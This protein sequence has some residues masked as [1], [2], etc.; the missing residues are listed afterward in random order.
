MDSGEQQVK[1]PCALTEG[2][3]V[4][5]ATSIEAAWPELRRTGLRGQASSL[6]CSIGTVGED[7]LP[8]VTPI[9]TVFLH[10][11]PGG[12]FFDRYTSALARNVD[13]NS[14]IC[15]MAV[16]SS[17]FFWL[18]SLVAGQFA[19][20]PGVRLYGTAGPLRE[21]S[22]VERSLV[23][24]RVRGTKWLKGSRLIWSSFTHVRD[25][26]FT[27]FRPVAYPSMMENLWDGA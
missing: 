20:A 9:G 8:T 26:H 21:A 27:S 3:R 11:S 16:D 22:P 23:D 12:F 18:R 2:N 4:T 19:Q 14:K 15:L 5:K 1:A 13:A 6:H 10:E 7:G 24:A 25:L 17:R